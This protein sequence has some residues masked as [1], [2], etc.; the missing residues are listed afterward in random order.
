MAELIQKLR[1]SYVIMTQP[2]GEDDDLD[3]RSVQRFL[4]VV[5]IVTNTLYF[6]LFIFGCI[7]FYLLITREIL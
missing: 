2:I 4:R 5:D 1:K 6:L 7:S 3:K